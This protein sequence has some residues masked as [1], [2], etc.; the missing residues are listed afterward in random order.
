MP[1]VEF[2]DAALYHP[3]LGYY[4]RPGVTTGREGDF[5]TS[6]DL[7]PA[8]GLLLSRQIS[9]IAA[10][11]S[12]DPSTPFHIIECGPGTGR[13]AR[14][15]ISGLALENAKLADR[16]SYTLVEI[17]PTLRALQQRTLEASRAAETL[18]GIEW[19]SWSGVIER[20]RDDRLGP[21]AGCVVANEF[22]DA[23]PVHRV[24]VQDGRLKEVHID[25]DGDGFHEVLMEPHT[26]RLARHLEELECH[27]VRLGEGQRAE[28][29][30][31]GL[32]WVAS[33]GRLF[34]DDGTGGAILVD[35]GHQAAQLYDA[36]RHRGSLLCYRRHQLSDDPYTRVGEQDMTAHLDFTSIAQ[37]ARRAGF[38]VAP[39]AT[40]LRFL[41]ALGIAQLLADMASAPDAGVT[42]ARERLA[43]HGL[44][45]PEGMGEIFKVM[46]LARGAA[47]ADLTGAKDPFG[48]GVPV[49]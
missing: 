36:S 28:F 46:L 7:H 49:R 33:L 41:V 30:L 29:G 5:Y 18:A 34:G 12:R 42:G 35:Y 10:R 6:P 37:G 11:T 13:L 44:M 9:Q 1:F 26:D 21:F 25:S 48:R 19:C 8:F 23:L 43:L 39:I 45:A 20:T 17:S 3:S 22:L 24:Q 40:Q 38:D 32:D 47:A 14:D 2:M 15:I 4:C 31:R 16:T 27:G